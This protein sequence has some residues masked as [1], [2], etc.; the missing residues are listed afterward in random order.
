MPTEKEE[1]SG[2]SWKS[3]TIRTREKS[4]PRGENK[5]NLSAPDIQFR[6]KI[7]KKNESRAAHSAKGKN[8]KSYVTEP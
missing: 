6:R 3:N 4:K 5:K 7:L 2:L 1:H 8:R